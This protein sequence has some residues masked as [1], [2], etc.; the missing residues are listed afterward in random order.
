M[1]RVVL[2]LALLALLVPILAGCAGT[3]TQPTAAPAQPTA[4]PALPTAALAQPTK[5]AAAEPT[6][7]ASDSGPIKIGVPSPLSAPGDY[8]SGQINVD[9]VKLAIQEL[10]DGGGVLGRKFEAVVADDQGSTSTGVSVVTKM[11]TEDKV[12]AIVGPWHGSVALAQSKTAT[13]YKVPILLHY[14]WPDEITAQHSD[15]VFRTSPYNSQ[16]AQLMM[17]FIKDKGYKHIAV[18]A[19][20]SAYGLGFA[21]GMKAAAEPAG[22]QITKRV[23]PSQAM[24]LSPQV[25]ELKS[26]TPPVDAILVACVYQPMY[27]IPKQAREVG[28]QCDII[29]GWDYPGWS[30][31]YWETTGAAGVGLY[32]PTFF[33][34]KLNLSASG[35]RFKEAY[36]K[37]YN[38]EPPIFAYYLY[39]E[40]M[41]VAQA[42]KQT[43]SADPVKIAANLKTMEFDGTTGKIKFESR[44]NP[45]DPVWNQWLGQQVFIMKITKQGQMQEDAEIVWPK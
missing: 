5:P 42:I 39:D 4:A 44:D 20:D 33:S 28:L 27:L 13:Q 40:V 35:L 3:A 9:T 1:R 37:A 22:I 15:F 16:I 23:F 38:H 8:K 2:Y 21:D 10:N 32:Y 31:E 43:N 17:P 7:P 12:V 24:D 34:K 29:A 25:T 26:L 41:M 18:M 30:P 14:S 36:K 45:N 6:R 11:I 19:E